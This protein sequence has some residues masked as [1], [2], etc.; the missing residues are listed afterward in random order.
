MTVMLKDK[1]NNNIPVG[2]DSVPVSLE[3]SIEYL[4][5]LKSLIDMRDA[6]Q[7]KVDTYAVDNLAYGLEDH[8]LDCVILT[9]LNNQ[10][11]E[12]KKIQKNFQYA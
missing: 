2:D 4:K 7:A 5:S 9:Y 11:E 10:I 12:K 6:L 3:K 8:R 1:N